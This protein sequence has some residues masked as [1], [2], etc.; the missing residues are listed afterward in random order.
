[1]Q[2]VCEMYHLLSVYIVPKYIFTII[3]LLINIGL[4][5]V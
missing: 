3:V 1:M 4:L 2:M 5:Y